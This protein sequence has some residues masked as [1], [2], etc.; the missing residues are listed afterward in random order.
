MHSALLVSHGRT[1]AMI[2]CGV[3]WLRR[4]K[5]MHLDAIL[6]THAHPDH[7]GGLKNGAPCDVF[8]TSDTWNALHTVPVIHSKFLTC[9]SSIEVGGVILEAFPVELS[10]PSERRLWGIESP[11]AG[12]MSSMLRIWCASM[13]ATTRSPVSS[14][15]SGMGPQ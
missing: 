1:A 10:I 11:L 4:V 8:A 13:I 12:I 7:V 9:R 15:T 3:D 5:H 6:L 2:D 14:F